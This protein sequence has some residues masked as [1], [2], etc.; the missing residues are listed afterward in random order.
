MGTKKYRVV[1]TCKSRECGEQG[2]KYHIAV[3]FETED[4][5]E[6]QQRVKYLVEHKDEL[7]F[8]TCGT[9]HETHRYSAAKEEPYIHAVAS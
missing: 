5:T 6:A 2:G 1:F 7:V 9:C 4:M 3:N 8:A